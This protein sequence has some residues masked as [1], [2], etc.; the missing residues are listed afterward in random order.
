MFAILFGFYIVFRNGPNFDLA[1][2]GSGVICFE[3]GH[4]IIQKYYA[5]QS[6]R[7]YLEPN[8]TSTM[9]PFSA[10]S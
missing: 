6:K 5:M 1:V 10:N 2:P 7:A 3:F 9:E 8:Q 4:A